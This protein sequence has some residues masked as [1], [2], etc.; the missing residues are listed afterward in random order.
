MFVPARPLAR[1]CSQSPPL[2]APPPV[3]SRP[4]CVA[5]A[6]GFPGI[7]AAQYRAVTHKCP[8]AEE[9]NY[10]KAVREQ[11][12]AAEVSGALGT[13]RAQRGQCTAHRSQAQ[14]SGSLP[15][16]EQFAQPRGARP[17]SALEL[18]KELYAAS[19]PHQAASSPPSPRALLS[20]AGLVRAELSWRLPPTHPPTH[21]RCRRPS[22]SATFTSPAWTRPRGWRP[23][24]SASARWGA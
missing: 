9:I 24:W 22:A 5:P 6:C 4:L 15:A 10:Q 12:L 21:C 16:H 18:A 19:P 13:A 8:G 23:C 2:E 20:C 7:S 1:P 11:K 17:A 14:C 3:L